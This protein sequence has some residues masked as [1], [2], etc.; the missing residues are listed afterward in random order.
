MIASMSLTHLFR[1]QFFRR[2]VR[3]F[4]IG[5]A[6]CVIR[7]LCFVRG[8]RRFSRRRFVSRRFLPLISHLVK[9][10]PVPLGFPIC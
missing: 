10:R 6:Q 7:I 9:T 4:A 8:C 3:S 1:R 2:R 5:D